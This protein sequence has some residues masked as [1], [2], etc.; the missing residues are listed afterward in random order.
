MLD[1]LCL[2]SEHLKERRARTREGARGAP[3][4]PGA[5]PAPLGHELKNGLYRGSIGAL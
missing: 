1:A 5:G 2:M 4:G 3:S